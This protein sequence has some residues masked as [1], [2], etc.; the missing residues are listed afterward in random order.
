MELL[1]L[2]KITAICDVRSVPY[3]RYNPQ[4]NREHLNKALS[5]H[6]DIAYVFMG[7]ELGARSDN[8]HCYLDGQVQFERLAE[9]PNFIK[10]LHRLRNGM[11]R[12]RIALLCAEKDPIMCH[13]TILICR[14]LR[15]EDL[16]IKHILSDGLIEKHQDAEKRLM[17]L[18][19]LV[20]DMFYPE[21]RCTPSR[22]A[23][24]GHPRLTSWLS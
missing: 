9:E 11:Q 22:F 14:N 3:S 21:Q 10:G 19:K 24:P 12:Y 23:M 13:R 16:E 18:H 5:K 2:Q 17:Q 6:D 15:A 7:K 8:P 1:R 4:F 20:P